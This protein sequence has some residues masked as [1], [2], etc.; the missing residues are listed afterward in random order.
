MLQCIRLLI[1]HV[2]VMSWIWN[3]RGVI[4]SILFQRLCFPDS[5]YGIIRWWRHRSFFIGH[6]SREFWMILKCPILKFKQNI[7]ST[8]NLT[9]SSVF[10]SLATKPCSSWLSSLSELAPPAPLRPPTSSP[11]EA[12]MLSWSGWK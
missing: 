8:S 11:P 5:Y 4:S 9:S 3:A 1:H 7:K 2:N 6:F 10:L 12:R